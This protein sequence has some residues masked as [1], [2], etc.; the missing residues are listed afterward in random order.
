MSTANVGRLDQIMRGCDRWIDPDP[1]PLLIE[2]Q[3]LLAECNE[4]GVLEQK[5]KDGVRVADVTYRPVVPK[6]RR[7]TQKQQREHKRTA[8]ERFQQGIAPGHEDNLTSAQY[9]R[10]AG[11]RLAPRGKLSRA[12]THLFTGRGMTVKGRIYYAE[13]AWRDVVS[14]KGVQFLVYHFDGKGQ[15]RYDLRGI[16][17]GDR[18][19]FV[20]AADRWGRGQ[21]RVSFF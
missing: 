21:L 3:Y 17:P 13:A 6:P 15:V 7:W 12:I 18:H 14:K 2:W 1:T 8:H 20:E 9:R 11:P 16:R 10:L 4:R 5:D 19:L